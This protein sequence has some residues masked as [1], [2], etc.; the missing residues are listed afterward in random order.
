MPLIGDL[1]QFSISDIIQFLNETRK[2]GT[3]RIGCYKGECTL[4]LM[5]AAFGLGGMVA[6]PVVYAW[7]KPELKSVGWV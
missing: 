4:V 7:L 5:E 1:S 3:V 6:A 2:S